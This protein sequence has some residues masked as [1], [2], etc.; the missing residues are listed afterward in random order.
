MGNGR[1]LRREFIYLSVPTGQGTHTWR[2]ENQDGVQDLNEFYLAINPDERNYAKIFTP[3]DEYI[4]A[5]TNLLNYRLLLDMPRSWRS[6]VGIKRMLSKFSFSANLN[7]ENKFTDD[8]LGIRFSP[9]A[10]SIGSD[11]LLGARKIVRLN[12][13][14][15]RGQAKYGLDFG[16]MRSSNKQLLTDGFEAREIEEQHANFRY[17]FGQPWILRFLI[18][19]KNNQASS[20][21]LEARNFV[22]RDR[23]WSPQWSWQP[24]T[25]FRL[26]ASYQRSDRINSANLDQVQSAQVSKW[27]LEVRQTQV[28]KST[29][30]AEFTF[31]DIDFVGEE[32]TAVGYELLQALRPG[33]NLQWSINWQVSIASGLQLQLNYHGRKSEQTDVIHT[34]RMQIS[35]LF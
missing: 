27:N 14:Y 9:F 8:D 13:F 10:R 26:T 22:I 1:E 2:D 21:F 25:K 33:Q 7:I 32:Q 20:D 3:T 30:Q 28:Q 4:L 6:A 35:A 11:D 18:N 19:Q 16:F 31:S 29:L 5:Y 17:S 34:G 24:S 15:N 23:S 12:G